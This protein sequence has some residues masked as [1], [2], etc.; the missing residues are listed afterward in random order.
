M[1]AKNKVTVPARRIADQ[2]EPF[3]CL[4]VAKISEWF[5]LKLEAT[6]CPA[7]ADTIRP[8][9]DLLLCMAIAECSRGI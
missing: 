7:E 5:I 1:S 4:A 2:V 8:I 3:L 6:F 9:V